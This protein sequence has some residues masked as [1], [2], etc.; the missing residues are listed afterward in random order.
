[1]PYLFVIGIVTSDTFG[2]IY[3]LS[4]HTFSLFSVFLTILKLHEKYFNS[5][6]RFWIFK[7]FKIFNFYISAR[8]ENADDCDDFNFDEILCG[9]NYVF[10]LYLQ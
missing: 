2:G 4:G 7:I 9:I 8:Q 6:V 1:M 3:I 10:S 5:C